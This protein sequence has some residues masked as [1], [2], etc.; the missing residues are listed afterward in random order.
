ML[1]VASVS[2][3]AAAAAVA[4]DAE[5]CADVTAFLVAAPWSRPLGT[6]LSAT[7]PLREL[8]DDIYFSATLS[9]CLLFFFF[10]LTNV[11]RSVVTRSP[12]PS[13]SG[14]G[15]DNAGDGSY[16]VFTLADRQDVNAE[17]D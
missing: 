1:A 11:V 8:V 6:C 4:C 2:A 16:S 17:R 3:A 14:I 10:F 9:A 7:G 15:D 13:N 5:A 12:L